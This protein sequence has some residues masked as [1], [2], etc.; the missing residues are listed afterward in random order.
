MEV[1]HNLKYGIVRKLGLDQEFMID[2]I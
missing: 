2:Y 1:I